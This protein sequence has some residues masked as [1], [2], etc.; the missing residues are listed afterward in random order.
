MS[1]KRR[2][3]FDR[4]G[5]RY[6]AIRRLTWPV[7]RLWLDVQL[8]DTGNVPSDGPVILAANHLSFIDSPL[9]MFGLDRRGTM[10]GKAEY[11]DGRI[12]SW[13]FPAA[14]MIP[15]DRSGRGLVESLRFAEQRL[16]DGEIIGLFPEGTRSRGRRA[17]S[18]SP[19]RRSPCAE[20]RSANR[21]CRDHGNRRCAGTGRPRSQVAGSNR[22]A[23]RI[24]DQPRS[25][26]DAAAEWRNEG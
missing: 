2:R 18:W 6:W 4:V 11:L 7:R 26:G 9:L 14:G 10:L 1:S 17:A 25:L 19:R 22:P 5:T 16:D 20:D 24:A 21:S 3:A 15:V 12:S 23:I 13:I 8:I